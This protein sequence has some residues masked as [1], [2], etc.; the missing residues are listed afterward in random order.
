MS[1]SVA[2]RRFTKLISYLWLN[3]MPYCYHF[4][5]HK[6]YHLIICTAFFS[7]FK[8][9]CLYVKDFLFFFLRNLNQLLILLSHNFN[10]FRSCSLKMGVSYFCL[11]TGETSSRRLFCIQSFVCLHYRRNSILKGSLPHFPVGNG[12]CP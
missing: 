1:I 6:H 2:Q 8:T 9:L 12:C 7:I 5:V 11:C 10:F 3:Y 4:T